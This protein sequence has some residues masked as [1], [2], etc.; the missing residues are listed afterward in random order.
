[1]KK[2]KGELTI[3]AFTNGRNTKVVVTGPK[4]IRA[5][6]LGNV[7]LTGTARCHEEDYENSW[8]GLC[9]ALG[10]ALQI[11]KEDIEKLSNVLCKKKSLVGAVYKN[12]GMITR[13]QTCPNGKVIYHGLRFK[14]KREVLG[15]GC[16]A[17]SWGFEVNADEIKDGDITW[18]KYKII[19]REAGQLPFSGWGSLVMLS[20]E[21]GLGFLWTK[22]GGGCLV[23]LL[24]HDNLVRVAWEDISVPEIAKDFKVRA[25]EWKN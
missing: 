4:D 19:E 25:A 13:E 3:R 17:E 12:L 22:D 15:R 16:V 14:P 8:I 9:I 23:C 11:P 20:G 21:R 18:R 1:M 7:S 10:R 2:I 5:R 24:D 6:Q